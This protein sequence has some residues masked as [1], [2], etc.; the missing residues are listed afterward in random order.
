MVVAEV[1]ESKQ[2]HAGSLKPSLSGALP[3]VTHSVGQSRSQDE[4]QSHEVDIYSSY[5]N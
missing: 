4:S 5:G 1:R 2:Q 3:L